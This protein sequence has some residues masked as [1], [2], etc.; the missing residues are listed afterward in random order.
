[1][2]TLSTN[3][4]TV[5][6]TR[7]SS[8]GGHALLLRVK[9]VLIPTTAAVVEAGTAPFIRMV[10]PVSETCTTGSR[11]RRLHAVNW[12]S[13]DIADSFMIILILRQKDSKQY[14]DN[15]YKKY[16]YIAYIIKTEI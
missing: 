5:K 3:N 16:I 15:I 10:V 9:A 14:F 7:H 4:N 1:M 2:L 12:K 6:L 11:Y 13:Q 8:A